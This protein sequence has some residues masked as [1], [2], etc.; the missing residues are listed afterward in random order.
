[1]SDRVRLST[2]ALLTLIVL[3]TAVAAFPALFVPARWFTA[4]RHADYGFTNAD[5][6][7]IALLGLLVIEAIVALLYAAIRSALRPAFRRDGLLLALVV[8][9]D[10]LV[11]SARPCSLVDRPSRFPGRPRQTTGQAGSRTSRATARS[12]SSSTRTLCR[13]LRRATSNRSSDAHAL[14]R[15]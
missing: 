15:W 3:T 12:A 11:C 10:A 13:A 9:G 1:M 8:V 5:V 6:V 14:R 7:R 4:P 2:W